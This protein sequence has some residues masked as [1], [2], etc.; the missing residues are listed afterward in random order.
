VLFPLGG[1]GYLP[2]EIERLEAKGSTAETETAQTLRWFM[3][4]M[5]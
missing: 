4:I 1:L 5:F 2:G 3:G